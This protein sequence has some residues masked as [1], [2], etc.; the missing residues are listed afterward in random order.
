VKLLEGVE[1]WLRA[2]ARARVA[3]GTEA[4]AD[5][6][7]AFEGL[8][9][10]EN[11]DSW[12]ESDQTGRLDP[13]VREAWGDALER[14]ASARALAPLR[15][16]LGEATRGP[17]LVEG[18]P[19]SLREAI[20]ALLDG[21]T[22]RSE[23]AAAELVRLADATVVRFLDGR[24]EVGERTA[25]ASGDTLALARQ[26]LVATEDPAREAVAWL[27][28]GTRPTSW[29]SLASRVLG[30]NGCEA[31]PARDRYRRI[32]DVLSGW[33]VASVLRSRVRVEAPGEGGAL[34]VPRV[35]AV[36]APGD[37]RIVSA[38]RK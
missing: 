13:V 1:T 36:E 20:G 11:A 32:A 37:V 31:F 17:L 7:L 4:I 18:A 5:A 2:D 22:A 12:A 10:R 6:A 19:T 28:G 14:H 9:S 15:R 23:A 33:R 16:S 27:A 29:A 21:P 38:W 30:P 24:A 35:V 26:V 34:P 3:G 8:A 25:I